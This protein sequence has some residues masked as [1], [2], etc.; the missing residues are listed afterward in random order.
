MTYQY[1]FAGWSLERGAPCTWNLD[2]TY[3]RTIDISPNARI[4]GPDIGR[5]VLIRNGWHS[6]PPFLLR[7]STMLGQVL[8][9]IVIASDFLGSS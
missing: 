6:W 8:V 5:D 9:D 7:W 1:Y 4:Y 2:N 3:K